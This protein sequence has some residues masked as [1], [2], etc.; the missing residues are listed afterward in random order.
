MLGTVLGMRRVVF[1]SNAID[2]VADTPGASEALLGAVAAGQLEVLYTHVT[3]DELAAIP[4]EP[5]RALLIELLASLGQVVPT[6][7]MVLGYSRLGFSR[8]SSKDDAEVIEGL[9]SRAVKHTP[10]A[11]IAATAR[12]EGCALVTN[13]ERLTKRSREQGIEVLTTRQLLA[14]FNVDLP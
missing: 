4:N 12:F 5:R 10:D 9:R 7:A 3:C 11:L 1:D 13:E 8:L 6:G 2:P 14:E